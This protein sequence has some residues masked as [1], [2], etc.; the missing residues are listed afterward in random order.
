MSRNV[1]P[2]NSHN[3]TSSDDTTKAEMCC[4]SNNISYEDQLKN[5]KILEEKNREKRKSIL[6]YVLL[7]FIAFLMCVS[8]ITLFKDMV[9]I[10]L[11]LILFTIVFV[12]ILVTCFTNKGRVCNG[13]LLDRIFDFIK[14]V[15]KIFKG[16]IP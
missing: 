3:G 2:G 15:A 1:S 9:F 13:H 5:I 4:D 16:F 11:L 10:T 6:F 12:V 8:L 7:G 14:D